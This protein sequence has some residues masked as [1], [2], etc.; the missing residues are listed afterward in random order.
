MRKTKQEDRDQLS[1][2]D[3]ASTSLGGCNECL[4]ND[5]L[6]WWS[7]RCQHGGCYDDYRARANPYDEAHPNEPPRTGWTEW[8]GD[9]AHW[10]RGGVSYPQ[11]I[12]PDY[13]HYE[14]STVKSCLMANVQVFQD[15]YISCSLVD[16]IGC[17]ECMKRY[18]NKTE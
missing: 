15:G 6:R 4:C 14:G 11:H 3:V 2:F 7:G 1:I 5:C 13:V 16:H 12:C 17:I 18:E 10:C 8:R 9:Q